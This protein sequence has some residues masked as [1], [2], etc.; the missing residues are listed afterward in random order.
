MTTAEIKP[1]PLATALLENLPKSPGVW[2]QA[3]ERLKNDRVGMVSLCV[4]MLFIALV[5]AAQLGLVAKNWQ[6][7][8]GVPFAAPH[9]VG[10]I[11]D[12]TQTAVVETVVGPN[13]DISDVDPLAPRYKEWEDRAWQAGGFHQATG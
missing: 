11:T 4:T 2:G 3:W 6:K 13:V 12:G 8:V 7:E 10:K 5:L 1:A 9:F